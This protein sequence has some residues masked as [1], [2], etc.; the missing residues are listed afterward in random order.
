MS[1]AP[2]VS[3][4]LALILVI[5]PAHTALADLPPA[6]PASGTGAAQPAPTSSSSAASGTAGTGSAVSDRHGA[7]SESAEREAADAFER[8]KVMFAAGDD[9]SALA[10]MQRARELSADPRYIF[11]LGLIHHYAG[12]CGAARAAFLEYLERAP[13]G[14]GCAEA[15][16]ALDTLEPICGIPA[17]APMSAAVAPSIPLSKDRD[18]AADAAAHPRSPNMLA[19]GLVA[20]G[21]ASGIASLASA[22]A[23]HNASSQIESLYRSAA[24]AGFAWE[25]CACAQDYQRLESRRQ[26]F[27]TLTWAFG[28]SAAALAGGGALVWLLDRE[29]ASSLA[30]S[31]DGVL[32]YRR[33]F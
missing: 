24:H 21:A 22:L 13:E 14:E 23:A 33:E 5:S 8:A 27:T 9:A 2:H 1:P 11:N 30:L 26:T 16:R 19:W 29:E 4:A 3:Y 10:L 7:A 18:P 6:A 15:R 12:D 17:P 28:I 20:G 25:A 31:P 32:A